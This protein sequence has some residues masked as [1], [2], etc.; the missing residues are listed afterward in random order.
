MSGQPWQSSPPGLLLRLTPAPVSPPPPSHR[1]TAHTR[2]NL[3]SVHTATNQ[4]NLFC[5]RNK[6]ACCDQPPDRFRPGVWLSLLKPADPLHAHAPKMQGLP[7]M[8]PTLP[9][10]RSFALKG[11]KR[12]L[13]RQSGQGI[14]HTSRFTLHAWWAVPAP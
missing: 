2:P 11:M 6:W 13:I 3:Q 1:H 12:Q 4:T 5:L 8:L 9:L 7:S 14:R 10:H